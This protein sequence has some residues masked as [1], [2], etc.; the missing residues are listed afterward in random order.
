VKISPPLDREAD[1]WHIPET[2]E[3]RDLCDAREIPVLPEPLIGRHDTPYG[4]S[5]GEVT[6]SAKFFSFLLAVYV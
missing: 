4:E 1:E 6:E 5:T 3:H 2:D